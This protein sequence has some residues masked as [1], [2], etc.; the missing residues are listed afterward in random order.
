MPPNFNGMKEV[1]EADYEFIIRLMNDSI[2]RVKKEASANLAV[3]LNNLKSIMYLTSVKAPID[4][5]IKLH[6]KARVKNI[7]R[8]GRPLINDFEELIKL[9][10][11]L[12]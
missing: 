1:V 5:L 2:N 11:R 12:E 7:I 4:D 9:A 3:N 6:E 8:N 10:G